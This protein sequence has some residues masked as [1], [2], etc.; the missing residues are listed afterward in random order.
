MP[1]S[2]SNQGEENEIFLKALLTKHFRL[3]LELIGAPTEIIIIRELSFG[4]D[5]EVPVWTNELSQLLD[6]KK[7]EELKEFFPKAKTSFK[8]DLSIN[9]INYSV[10]FN[11]GA[12]P[13]IVN[14]TNRAGFLDVCTRI[15]V[16]IDKLDELVANYWSLRISNQIRED[17]DNSNPLSPF[18]D[19]QEYLS[20]ILEY[21]IFKGTG[22]G[23][24][25]FPA[26]KVLIFQD[27]FDPH[28]YKI[29]S[30]SDIINEKWNDF[31]FSIRS[32]KG[33]PITVLPDGTKVDN[34][35]PVRHA[36]LAPWVRFHPPDHPFPKGALHVRV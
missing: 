29:I 25:V 6:E 21:F 19:Y 28:T 31:R 32:K 13:A 27:T 22:R 20:P 33:M 11:G 8:A 30:E 5:T 36:L 3:G 7:Y 35:N 2:S 14:H 16:N 26:D 18:K 9:G 10:K 17:I 24:S 15:G 12:K 1:S 23:I 34:Y 4:P